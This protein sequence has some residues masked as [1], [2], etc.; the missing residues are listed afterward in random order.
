MA[1]HFHQRTAF[2]RKHHLCDH[3]SNSTTTRC[4]CWRGIVFRFRLIWRISI[5]RLLPRTDCPSYIRCFRY[6]LCMYSHCSSSS[7]GWSGSCERFAV[8]SIIQ[9][10][11]SCLTSPIS[12]NRAKLTCEI[13]VDPFLATIKS[14]WRRHSAW[15]THCGLVASVVRISNNHGMR[16]R[17]YLPQLYSVTV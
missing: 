9:F 11:A 7:L 8:L 10:G 14:L 1:T 2:L 15:F 13:S 12:S 16:G 6:W 17:N 5:S 4:S 3:R